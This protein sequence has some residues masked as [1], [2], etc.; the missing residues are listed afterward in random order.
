MVSLAAFEDV[1]WSDLKW[2]DGL[3]EWRDTQIKEIT[4]SFSFE[5]A[6]VHPDTFNLL[7]EEPMETRDFTYWTSSKDVEEFFEGL[8]TEYNESTSVVVTCDVQAKLVPDVLRESSLW[9]DRLLVR[10]VDQMLMLSET[11]A[12]AGVVRLHV[13]YLTDRAEVSLVRQS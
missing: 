12:Q 6:H 5:L 9:A 10:K 8:T 4:D 7:W 2:E 3:R 1:E 11:T 13:E